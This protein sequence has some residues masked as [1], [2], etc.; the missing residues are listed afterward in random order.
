MFMV[1]SSWQATASLREFT[2]FIW[3]NVER[4]LS[5]GQTTQAVSPPVGC[6]KPHPPDHRH[7]L[8]LL[9][10]KAD[11][12]FTIPW[13]VEGWVDLV[14]AVGVCSP[15]PRLC[16]VVVFTKNPQLPTVGF[17]PWTSH[18]AVRHVTTARPVKPD[19]DDDD[20]DDDDKW[21]VQGMSFIAAVLLLNMDDVDTFIC[22]ANLLNKPC[23][24]AFF[25]L[26]ENLVRTYSN[27]DLDVITWLISY[28][29]IYQAGHQ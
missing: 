12:H 25:R 11:I 6:Q 17:E 29:P 16:I 1:L 26:D 20:G 8:L 3:L 18:T 28:R 23:E 27:L 7:L 4:N 2:W 9:S 19:D 13:R 5:P 14:T 21:Q 10:L 22:F 24:V 15:C